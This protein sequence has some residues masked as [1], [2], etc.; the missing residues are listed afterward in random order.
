[1][2]CNQFRKSLDDL[3]TL[4]GEH[5][6]HEQ[7]CAQCARWLRQLRLI[8]ATLAA[9]PRASPAPAFASRVRTRLDAR[10]QSARAIFGLAW[11]E[12]IAACLVLGAVGFGVYYF[13]VLGSAAAMMESLMTALSDF[14]GKFDWLP[15]VP[16][17]RVDLS[18]LH[19]GGLLSVT[20]L[21]WL[22]LTMLIGAIALHEAINRRASVESR[23]SDSGR[24]R[25]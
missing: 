22:A 3:E 21:R 19:T 9:S 17:V 1:M 20:I 8:A 23:P 10:Q 14:S 7:S 13:D 2:D 15:A 25:R 11:T 6:A 12:A 16:S 18:W 4:A 5:A 24:N